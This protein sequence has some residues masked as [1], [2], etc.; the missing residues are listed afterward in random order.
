MFTFRN[1]EGVLVQRSDA[2][3]CVKH[4]QTMAKHMKIRDLIANLK[5]KMTNKK[6]CR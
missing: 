5:L 1:P 2:N 4:I 3:P 6:V